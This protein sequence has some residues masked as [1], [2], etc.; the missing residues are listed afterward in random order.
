MHGHGSASSYT[1]QKQ[2]TEIRK[3][4]NHQTD[5]LVPV[6]GTGK[7]SNNKADIFFQPFCTPIANSMW[8]EPYN[9]L[10]T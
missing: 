9:D 5:S 1:C 8:G 2:P 3:Y 4:N 10:I 6:R 7:G